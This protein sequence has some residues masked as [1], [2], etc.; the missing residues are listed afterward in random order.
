[1]SFLNKLIVSALPIVPKALVGQFSRK[2]IAGVALQ[3]AVRVIRD[4]NTKRLMAT[5]DLLGE[6]IHEEAQAATMKSTLIQMFETIQRSTL[7][8]N[9]SVKLS[10]L[11]LRIDKNVCFENVRSVVEEARKLGN[12]VRI[13]MEDSTTTGDTIEIYRRLREQGFE[14]VGIV[15]QAYL[16]R[17]DADIRAL[18]KLR[19]NF[20]VCK[21]IYVESPDIAYHDRDEIRRN[22]VLLVRT[23]I[24]NG[25]YV[26]IATHDEYLVE[27]SYDL[28][29]R[30]S[31]DRSRYEFQMLLGVRETLR[32]QILSDGHRLRVYVPY[33]E[34]WYAYCTRRLKENP[35]IAG[36][37]VKALLGRNGTK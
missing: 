8:S 25:C 13:D 16:K 15:I 21:G 32:D 29:Q 26:G 14:N 28:I 12:F 35:Q 19:A 4:L 7:D 3:D 18:V 27:K 2:Y 34:Q 6:D 10:Q 22:F 11:G 23:I 9:V 30:N 17:S 36:Y 33:G 31:P 5:M 20:R 24:E 1:M 37:V